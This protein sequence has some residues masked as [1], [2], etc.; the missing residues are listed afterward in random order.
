MPTK[1]IIIKDSENQTSRVR[2]NISQE[3]GESV[4]NNT[5]MSDTDQNEN[6][7]INLSERYADGIDMID[8][9]HQNKSGKYSLTYED[10]IE[11]IKDNIDYEILKQDYS[12]S[13]MEYVDTM[14]ELM[15]ETVITG[16]EKIIISDK[17][18]PKSMV[19]S[20]FEK[21]DMMTVQYVVECLRNNTSDIK[22][23]KNYMLATLY[24]APLTMNTYYKQ[25]VSH[26]L[27]G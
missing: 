21:Y 4:S 27:Y 22:N 9:M 23:I 6:N 3:V 17:C 20:R 5:N 18:V 16:G 26:D 15:A 2:E 13:D 25:K 11:F 24:N 10:Y 7:L 14:V 8:F 12:D 19:I 1:L